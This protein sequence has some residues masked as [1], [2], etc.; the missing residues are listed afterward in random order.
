L[1]FLGLKVLKIL[2]IENDE[3][4]NRSDEFN[5][6]FNKKKDKKNEFNNIENTGV[7]KKSITKMCTRRSIVGSSIVVG[8]VV[9]IAP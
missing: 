5:S 4:S 8:V 3:S 7:L 6:K 9:A 2:T 1:G